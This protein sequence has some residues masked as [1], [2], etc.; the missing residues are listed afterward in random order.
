MDRF[1]FAFASS[2]ALFSA[3]FFF[4]SSFRRCLAAAFL[5]AAS[6]LAFS[7]GCW[8]GA[9]P[10]PAGGTVAGTAVGWADE[11][12]GARAALVAEMG[13][14]FAAACDGFITWGCCC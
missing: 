14:F 7:A 12:A 4:A 6:F 1:A 2:A 13:I 11:G 10:E 9:A 3:R 8:E 5:A